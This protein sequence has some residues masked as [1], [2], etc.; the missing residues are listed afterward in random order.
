MQSPPP[1]VQDWRDIARTLGTPENLLTPAPGTSVWELSALD[2]IAVVE[3]AKPD[4]KAYHIIMLDLFA[5][6]M[7][8]LHDTPELFDTSP[9]TLALRQL[10]IPATA[11]W[12]RMISV[13]SPELPGP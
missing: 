4:P 3:A 6:E 8:L 11:E 5:A 7:R 10:G 1:P 12:V 2:I 13:D 9:V